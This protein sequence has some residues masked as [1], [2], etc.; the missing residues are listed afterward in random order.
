M[1]ET[2]VSRLDAEQLC[3][4]IE[5]YGWSFFPEGEQ[6]WVSGWQT[7]KRAYPLTIDLTETWLSMSVTPMIKLDIDWSLWPDLVQHILE[8]NDQIQL[9]KLSL[10]RDGSLTLS[11][12]LLTVDLSYDS[13][14]ESLGILGYYAEDLYDRLFDKIFQ[15]GLLTPHHSKFLT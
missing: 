10:D 11:C 2:P 4:Y 9:V 5:S 13:F 3:S 12:Q 14:C 8:L 6:R 1:K 7:E 15:S